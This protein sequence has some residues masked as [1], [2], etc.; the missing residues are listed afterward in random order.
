M[1]MRESNH[2]VTSWGEAS[3]HHMIGMLIPHHAGVTLVSAL[4]PGYSKRHVPDAVQDC[5]E[6]MTWFWA[7]PLHRVLPSFSRANATAHTA[8]ACRSSDAVWATAGTGVVWT[9]GACAAWHRSDSLRV[10]WVE[11]VRLGLLRPFPWT[12]RMTSACRPALVLYVVMGLLR[13]RAGRTCTPGAG[14]SE[15]SLCH[16]TLQLVLGCSTLLTPPLLS[17]LCLPAVMDSWALVIWP[18]AS[19]PSP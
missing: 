14:T 17:A 9:C 11:A 7:T 5:V 1:R 4:A 16:L 6:A 2:C 12:A 19:P 13:P 3:L 15:A 8:G 18:R 10:Y